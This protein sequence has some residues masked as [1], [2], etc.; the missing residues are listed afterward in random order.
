MYCA[1]IFRALFPFCPDKKTGGCQSH[2][3]A[4]DF[5]WST[6]RLLLL[7]LQY[8]SWNAVGEQT[9]PRYGKNT[10]L[11]RLLILPPEYLYCY[12]LPR[13]HLDAETGVAIIIWM[14]LFKRSSILGKW[15]SDLT[16][17]TQR[18]QGQ[19]PQQISFHFPSKEH[20]LNKNQELLHWGHPSFTRYYR[21][22]CV[23]EAVWDSTS[24]KRWKFL[25][26][27]NL[28]SQYIL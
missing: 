20:T 9:C 7:K 23:F 28:F 5:S 17:N 13:T 2:V 19:I 6:S 4:T 10:L 22:Q 15:T 14:F 27:G 12:L 11:P 3:M 25:A 16:K 26:T 18:S 1:I 8:E 24:S 21:L